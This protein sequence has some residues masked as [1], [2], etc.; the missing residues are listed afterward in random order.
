MLDFK[1][2]IFRYGKA[3]Y[4]TK[5][6]KNKLNQ[7]PCTFVFIIMEDPGFTGRERQTDK[8]WSQYFFFQTL[9][10]PKIVFMQDT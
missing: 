5:N 10:I 3:A 7:R 4:V 1:S 8:V 2:D 9:N 6:S